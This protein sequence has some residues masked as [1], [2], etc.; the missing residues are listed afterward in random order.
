MKHNLSKLLN[1]RIHEYKAAVIIDVNE[2][3]DEILP[4]VRFHEFVSKQMLL[5]EYVKARVEIFLNQR[6]CYSFRKNKFVSLDSASVDQLA[7]MDKNFVK[8]ILGR[9]KTL[10]RI[11]EMEAAKGQMK[12]EFDGNEFI[13][14]AEEES[15][16]KLLKAINK[17]EGGPHELQ[18]NGSGAA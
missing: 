14:Y 6:N 1:E 4:R 18:E 9:A 11:R 3:V 10:K 16:E 7:A 13:G 8:G 15:I 2:V 12:I 5:R 17:Q